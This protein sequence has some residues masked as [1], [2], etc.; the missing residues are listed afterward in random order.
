MFSVRTWEENPLSKLPHKVKK[1]RTRDLTD[2]RSLPVPGKF[3]QFWKRA[4][5]L[6]RPSISDSTVSLINVSPHSLL[7]E[8]VNRGVSPC[9]ENGALQSG[10]KIATSLRRA[11]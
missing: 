8:A 4:R 1:N 2:F 6:D 7:T 11:V 9:S 3:L 10:R 5:R